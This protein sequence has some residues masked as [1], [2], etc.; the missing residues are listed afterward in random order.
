MPSSTERS[1]G[2]TLLEMLVV[3]LIVSLVSALLMQ[4][5]L[6]MA[7]VY[8][9]VDRKQKALQSNQLTTGW[10]KD[11]VQGLVNGADGI[12][13]KEYSAQPFTGTD[14]GFEG[15]GLA[16]LSTA[17][18]VVTP[19]VV[20][21]RFEG[22]SSGELSLIYSERRFGR[23]EVDR[24]V[25]R[26][27]PRGVARISY[28]VADQWHANFPPAQGQNDRLPGAIRVEVDSPR[29]PL[30]VIVRPGASTGQYIAPRKESP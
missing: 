5:F 7:G 8:G 6:Y 14:S 28:L 19:L 27:W 2:F 13:W 25:V 20:E 26:H 9:V 3:L 11:S 30:Y 1:K 29:A 18:G 16:A 10:L 24:H 17:G 15:L 22:G 21:W 23:A 12:A 4:G